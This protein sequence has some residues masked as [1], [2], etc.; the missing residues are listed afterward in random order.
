MRSPIFSKNPSI[1]SNSLGR[2]VLQNRKFDYFHHSSHRLHVPSGKI[3]VFF[4]NIS[5]LLPD[6]WPFQSAY[7]AHRALATLWLAHENNIGFL[8][9]CSD[10]GYR[11]VQSGNTLL[12]DSN[13]YPSGRELGEVIAVKKFHADYFAYVTDFN[14]YKNIKSLLKSDPYAPDPLVFSVEAGYYQMTSFMTRDDFYDISQFDGKQNFPHLARF[15]KIS[16]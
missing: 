13:T 14:H 7:G 2:V 16:S 4:D 12:V 6:Y 5:E 9:T 8:P 3:V 10:E 11:A 1:Y 15:D